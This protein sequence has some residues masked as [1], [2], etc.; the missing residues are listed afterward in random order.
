MSP[1]GRL[2]LVSA[3]A[4]DPDRRHVVV[5]WPA[6]VGSLA[7]VIVD[8]DA[9]VADEDAGALCG[10]L[11]RLS[12]VLWDTYVRP[13]SAADDDDERERRAHERQQLGIVVAALREPNLADGSGVLFVSYSTVEESAHRL[14]RVLAR[15]GDAALVEAVAADVQLEIDAVMR[16]ELGDL[17]GR[18]VQAVALDRLDVSPVQVAAADELLRADPLG[19]Q[20]L[21]AAVDPAAGCVAAAHWLAAAAV[22][23]ADA[24]GNTP[25]GVFAEADDIQPVSV[26]VP[27]LVVEQ[28]VDAAVPPREV[29]LGLLRTAVA[30]GNGEVADPGDGRD[31]ALAGARVRAAMVNPRRPARDLLEHLLDGIAS[32]R[33]LYEEYAGAEDSEGCVDGAGGV[34]DNAVATGTVTGDGRY[35]ACEDGR[36]QGEEIADGF[37][38][39]VRGQV[40]A[41]RGRLI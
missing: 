19:A 39:L 35:D 28:I 3:Y 40:A 32:C 34:D 30:A 20:L 16:A 38:V 5:V 10:A 6:T 8:L 41:V 33:L 23:A 14:G 17:S 24:S 21:S 25:G 26:D 11:S 7:H 37:A 18:A 31:E 1:S 4:F 2:P 29:V 12:Q 36:P 13:A 9:T 15:F 27:T 22:V